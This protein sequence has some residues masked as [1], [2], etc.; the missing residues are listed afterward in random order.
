MCYGGHHGRLH[1]GGSIGVSLTRSQ[2][3]DTGSLGV[4][5]GHLGQK[6]EEDK[7]VAGALSAFCWDQGLFEGD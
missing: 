1:G 2:G 3:F 7:G 6:W 4:G 5:K